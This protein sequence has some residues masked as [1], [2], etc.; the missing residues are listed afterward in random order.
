MQESKSIKGSDSKGSDSE[1]DSET[2]LDSDDLSVS[3]GCDS[4]PDLTVT[5][6]AH[7]HLQELLKRF[8]EGGPAA[9]QRASTAGAA[10]AKVSRSDLPPTLFPSSQ[11][12]NRRA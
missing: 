12:T 4:N 6:T 1:G 3:S 9:D 5:N 8:S 2:E 11:D 7:E 10:W